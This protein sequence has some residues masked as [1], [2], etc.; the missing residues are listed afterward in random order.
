[1]DE[2]G[3]G[4]LAAE[5]AVEPGERA[6]RRRAEVLA[7]CRVREL[8]ERCVLEALGAHAD[9]EDAHVGARGRGRDG[10]RG[11]GAAAVGPVGQDDHGAGLAAGA[12]QQLDA[13]RCCVEEVGAAAQRGLGAER[14][15]D[16]ARVGGQREHDLGA[17]IERHDADALVGRALPR[18]RARGGHGVADGGAVHALARVDDEDCAEPLPPA[19]AS[20]GS[21]WRSRTGRAVLADADLARRDGG[22][23]REASGPTSAPGT[24]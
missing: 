5:I 8:L 9:R 23:A 21:T 14:G 15:A 12:A 3:V 7:R 24:S 13:G 20:A 19:S 10:S 6:A 11:G 2:I 1:M 4:E 18:E 16:P 22:P 17:A